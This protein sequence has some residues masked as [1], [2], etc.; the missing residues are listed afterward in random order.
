MQFSCY[1]LR[2]N[3]NLGIE[4]RIDNQMPF[5]LFVIISLIFFVC[6]VW[7][8]L[9]GLCGYPFSFGLL[10]IASVLIFAVAF[11]LSI[12]SRKSIC[13]LM[14]VDSNIIVYRHLIWKIYI[15]FSYDLKN[16]PLVFFSRPSVEVH[17][18]DYLKNNGGHICIKN[19]NNAPSKIYT[20]LRSYDECQRV[21]SY[22]QKACSIK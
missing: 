3:T 8:G 6:C 19:N 11:S 4:A 12:A 17:A 9:L 18:G 5:V 7:L 1:I 21:L 10:F 13:I 16:R 22:I 20:N 14:V 2:M 15:R